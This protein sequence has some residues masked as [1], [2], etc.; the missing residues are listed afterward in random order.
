MAR[1][2]DVGETPSGQRYLVLEFVDGKRIDHWCDEHALDIDSRVRLFLQVCEAIAYAHANLIVHRDLKPSN[3]FVQGD[4]A[5]K[6]LDFGMAKLL[7][8]GGAEEEMTELTRAGGAAFTPEYAAP[9]QF[10]GNPITVTTDVYSLGVVLFVLLSGR[11]PYGEERNTPAQL[12]RAINED[13]PRRLSLA[14]TETTG[15][16]AQIAERRATSP[17]QLRRALRGDLETIVTRALKKEPAERYDSVQSFANDLRR[18]LDHRPILA[19]ADSRIYRL[20]K[21][22]RRHRVGLAISAVLLL[23]VLAGVAGILWQARIARLEAARAIAV[24][25]F[26]TG[27]FDDTRNTRTGMQVR[28]ASAMDILQN[29]AERLKTD[30]ATTPDVRDEIYEMLVEIFDSSGDGERSMALARARLTAAEGAYGADDVR[31]APAV[32]MLAGVSLN[33]GDLDG[34]KAYLARDQVLLDKARDDDSLERARFLLWQGVYQSLTD[35]SDFEINSLP[36]AVALLRRKYPDSDERDVALMMYTQLCIGN[37]QLTEAEN[38]AGE[39]LDN[40]KRRYGLDTV[41]VPQAQMMQAKIFIQEK[42][43][44]QALS[45]SRA[46]I[47]AL[48]K[49]E[50]AEHPDVAYGRTV[51]VNALLGMGRKDEARAVFADAEAIRKSKFADE[52]MLESVYAEVAAKLTP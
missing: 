29:G 31:V 16:T 27:L 7:D 45:V 35:K 38:A 41:Y 50:S 26:L 36:Q 23:A 47:P 52:K 33:H 49:F 20:R 46:A 24:K 40:A 43:F 37:E 32:T 22:A 25:G 14:A 42:K 8:A 5:A 18:Y 19:R 3:I 17:E 13:E 1:L 15:N 11:R 30:L 39:M 28:T 44:D 48:I 12:A 2:L 34:A 21:Y 9:E 6:V 10:D 4:G 51:E